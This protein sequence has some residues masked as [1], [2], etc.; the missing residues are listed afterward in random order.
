M[1][2]TYQLQELN[3]QKTNGGGAGMETSIMRDNDTV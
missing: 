1:V 2:D 3:I